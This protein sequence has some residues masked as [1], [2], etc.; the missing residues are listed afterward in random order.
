MISKVTLVSGLLMVLAALLLPPAAAPAPEQLHNG[1]VLQS[2]WPPWDSKVTAEPMAVPYL[3]HPPDV[4]PIDRGRQLFVDD[5]LIQETTLTRSWHQPQYYEGNP[6]IKPDTKW[7]NAGTGAFA[8]PFSGGAWYDPHDKT[9]KMWYTCGFLRNTCYATSTDGIHWTKPKLDVVPG[10][11][12]V[13]DHVK[14]LTPTGDPALWAQKQ[15]RPIDTNSVWIDYKDDPERRYKIFYTSWLKDSEVKSWHLY[16]RYSRDGIHW[17]PEPVAMSGAL[18][19]HTNAHYDP[20]RDKW[21]IHVRY[22]DKLRGRAR[23]Y[24][25][26]SDPAQATERA[27]RG[28]ERLVPWLA[29]DK[30]DPH[31]PNPKYSEIPPQLY[32]FDT[33]AYESLLLGYFSIWQGPE[34]EICEE[35]HIQKRNEVLLGYSRDGFHYSRPDRRPFF[36][37]TEKPGAWNWGNVQSASGGTIVVGDKLYLYFSARAVPFENPQYDINA[38]TGLAFLRRDGFASMNSL[39]DE[40]TLITRLVR[41]RGKYLFVNAR[42][43]QGELRAEVLDANGAVVQPFTRDR[44]EPVMADRTLQKITW[45]GATD[46]SE[47]AGKPVRFKFYLRLGELYSF[48]VSP[49]AFGASH[50]YVGSGGP[51]YGSFVDV[52]G[53]RALAALP[54]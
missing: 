2:P 16:C 29:S 27:K 21:V 22:R 28:A 47:L 50:G 3:Q 4:I 32:H 23:A 46:L 15:R 41:F 49:D 53:D 44:C 39:G 35:N 45:K 19:D 5:F 8:A 48:W 12:I 26:D 24:V 10:T 33:I 51:G 36:R 52:E 1:I 13:I 11:N 43:P 34:N 17:S 18:G 42:S 31:N 20:F 54:K 40:G 14:E 30:L 38:S 7:E 6:V 25:E 37:A 9:F